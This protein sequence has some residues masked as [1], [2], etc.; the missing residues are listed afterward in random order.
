VVFSKIKFTITVIQNTGG[1]IAPGTTQVEYGADIAF[2]IT[3]LTSHR[4]ETVK[5]DGGSYGPITNHTFRDVKSNHIIEAL[6]AVKTFKITVICDE[7][8]Y[9]K[10]GTIE[11]ACGASQ[12]FTFGTADGKFISDVKIDHESKGQ[13]SS[14]TLSDIEADHLIEV[15]SQWRTFEIVESHDTGGKVFINGQL[16]PGKVLVKWGISHN[17]RCEI[18]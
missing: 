1:T 13:Q 4:I 17:V 11:V 18:G 5:V 8:S 7:G 2:T 9:S 3:P 12:T 15:F 10:P 14:W 6:F 16:N